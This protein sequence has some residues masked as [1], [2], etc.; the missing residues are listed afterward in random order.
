MSLA[1]GR[2]DQRVTFQESIPTT[3]AFGEEVPTWQ[4]IATNPTVWARVEPLR[5]REFFAA[6][7]M[8]ASAEV[9]IT[10]RWRA[11]LNER[12]RLVWRGVPHEIVAPPI[13]VAGR[14]VDLEFMCTSGVR[15]GR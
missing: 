6:G 9:R 15:D 7:Q 4:D 1:A 14:Q 8:Q 12:M 3:N 13:D 5:G 11:D 2:F 10:V